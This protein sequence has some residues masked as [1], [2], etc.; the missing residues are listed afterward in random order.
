MKYEKFLPMNKSKVLFLTRNNYGR[1]ISG[2]K[3]LS[4]F[5]RGKL[6]D[7]LAFFM[8]SMIP[9]PINED[10]FEKITKE[11][12]IIKLDEDFFKPIHKDN[13]LI[14][15]KIG[16]LSERTFWIK[17]GPLMNSL[18]LI[19]EN[20]EKIIKGNSSALTME[21]RC[22]WALFV[23][24]NLRIDGKTIDQAFD[25]IGRNHG[26][27]FEEFYRRLEKAANNYAKE[28]LDQ[29]IERLRKIV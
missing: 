8:G 4:E 7:W 12:K 20:V 15:G 17:I 14:L 18:A 11:V 6:L 28:V 24:E 23:Y 26:I 1:E 10:D 16:V 29:L 9:S 5:V 27:G 3:D 13:R 2:N 19:C 22:D 25:E 21:L